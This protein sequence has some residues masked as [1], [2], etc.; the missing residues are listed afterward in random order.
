MSS[1][2]ETKG[3][4]G[5][6][7]CP[8]DNHRRC[9]SCCGCS[10]KQ[11]CKISKVWSVNTWEVFESRLSTVSRQ[12]ERRLSRSSQVSSPQ[13]KS[14]SRSGNLIAGSGDK[15][16]R[17]PSGQSSSSMRSREEHRSSSSRKVH[18]ETKLSSTRG[19]SPSTSRRSSKYVTRPERKRELS[20]L[21]DSPSDDGRHT[22]GEPASR[23]F[24][25]VT[26][27]RLFTEFR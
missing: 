6:V 22:K 4:C 3:T 11:P 21:S 24:R 25:S 7:K 9:V 20:S 5:H 2:E 18:V 19:S 17:S 8:W 10:R 13:S 23:R 14:A 26:K 16:S 1:C 27:K 12:M 15:S